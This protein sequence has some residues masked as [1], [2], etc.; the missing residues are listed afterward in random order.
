MQRL[1]YLLDS[2]AGIRLGINFSP[3]DENA[4]VSIKY[5]PKRCKNQFI[6]RL[7][8]L[9]RNFHSMAL[10]AC[11]KIKSQPKQIRNL[12]RGK[13]NPGDIALRIRPES[14]IYAV[15]KD[16]DFFSQ[17]VQI[18]G[19]Q[20]CMTCNLDSGV[21]MPAPCKAAVPYIC[22][23]KFAKLLA[24][25]HIDVEVFYLQLAATHE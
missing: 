3:V 13:Y 6:F 19:I 2:Y 16:F 11:R 17:I 14:D 8:N 22:P 21:A 24:Q 5:S 18:I 12:P 23:D 25:G 15:K 20:Y 10:Y 9:A 4:S 7:Q 1:A